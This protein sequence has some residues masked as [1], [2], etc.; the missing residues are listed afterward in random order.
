MGSF[1]DV[2]LLSYYISLKSMDSLPYR[3]QT[4]YLL[5]AEGAEEMLALVPGKESNSEQLPEPSAATLSDVAATNGT[6]AGSSTAGNR[7]PSHPSSPLLN[8]SCI[9]R[10]WTPTLERR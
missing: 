2:E 4:L 8:A 7:Q 3:G 9:P 5:L 1:G 10:F 6:M